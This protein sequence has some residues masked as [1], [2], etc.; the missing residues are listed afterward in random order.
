MAFNQATR[1]DHRALW[2]ELPLIVFI[3]YDMNAIVHPT[4]RRLKMQDPRVV[5]K[6]QDALHLLFLQHK[7]YDKLA[8]LIG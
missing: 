4:A 6:Y 7:I 3:G 2:I 8:A 5:K 1:S